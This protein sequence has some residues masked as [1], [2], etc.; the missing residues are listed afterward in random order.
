MKRKL[1]ASLFVWICCLTLG[2]GSMGD[3][4]SVKAP[5]PDKNIVATVVD[6][7][8]VSLE[9]EKFSCD[10]NTY[11]TGKMGKADLSIDFEK[12]R[13]ILFV[14]QEGRLKAMVTLEDHKQIELYL[15]KDIPCFGT[16]SFADVRIATGD[17]KKIVLHGK[18]QANGGS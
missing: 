6:Q 17:I 14:E 5:E 1:S 2:M 10:G 13:S 15:E 9:L 12:I 3:P 7:D 16:S 4:V 18:K 8:D 11:V